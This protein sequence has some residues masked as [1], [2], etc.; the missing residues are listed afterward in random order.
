MVFEDDVS[1]LMEYSV[2]AH[3]VARREAPASIDSG[4]LHPHS[5]LKKAHPGSRLAAHGLWPKHRNSTRTGARRKS[6]LPALAASAPATKV[7]GPRKSQPLKSPRNMLKQIGFPGDINEYYEDNDEEEEEEDNDLLA[8]GSGSG[9]S[10]IPGFFN[11]EDQD[12]YEGNSEKAQEEAEEDVDDDDDDDDDDDQ[13]NENVVAEKMA[14]SGSGC[15]AGDC[16]AELDDKLDKKTDG[17]EDKNVLP[18]PKGPLSKLNSFNSFPLSFPKSIQNPKKRQACSAP[19]I[20]A[21]HVTGR[22]SHLNLHPIHRSVH[23]C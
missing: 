15:V 10:S 7:T 13:L 6:K 17:P 21:P 16:D 3:S 9:A 20:G 5:A 12:L 22:T 4:A 11:E 23:A 1:Y 2:A 18:E 14:S 19:S 8:Q